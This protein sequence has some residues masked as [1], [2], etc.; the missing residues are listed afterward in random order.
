MQLTH[1]HAVC[2]NSGIIEMREQIRSL[3]ERI[4]KVETEKDTTII[5]ANAKIAKSNQRAK[6]CKQ[7]LKAIKS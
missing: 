1:T 7:E 2:L 3:E 5:V 4:K 6:E